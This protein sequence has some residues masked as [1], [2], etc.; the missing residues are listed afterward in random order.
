MKILEEILFKTIY[1]YFLE[2][3][4]E[5]KNDPWSNMVVRMQMKK[6]GLFTEYE[7]YSDG[8]NIPTNHS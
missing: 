8:E 6:D 2:I 5:V 4:E 7:K 1:N 3:G